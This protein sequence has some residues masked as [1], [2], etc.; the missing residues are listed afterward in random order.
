MQNRYYSRFHAKTPGGTGFPKEGNGGRKS[1]RAWDSQVGKVKRPLHNR[2]VVVDV[3][4]VLFELL[5]GTR[6]ETS[7]IALD[8]INAPKD[9]GTYHPVAVLYC[10]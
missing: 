10:L 9:P 4:N 1:A 2:C 6:V 8:A 3:P 7:P 5:R